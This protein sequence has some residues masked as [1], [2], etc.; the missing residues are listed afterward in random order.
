PEGSTDDCSFKNVGIIYADFVLRR[1]LQ[2][3]EKMSSISIPNDIEPLVEAVY[4]S[5]PTFEGKLIEERLRLDQQNRQELNLAKQRA[6]PDST[7]AD[8]PF[9]NFRVPF[10]EDDPDVAQALRAETR[11]GDQSV[12]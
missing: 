4:T 3:L 7:V 8:D 10:K 9:A 6:W 2:E 5:V 12:A 1:T 11:L